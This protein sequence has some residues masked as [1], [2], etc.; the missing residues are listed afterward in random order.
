M[1]YTVLGPTLGRAGQSHSSF[2]DL[3]AAGSHI[4]AQAVPG[5][6]NW[7]TVRPGGEKEDL[8]GA[9]PASATP[10]ST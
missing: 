10:A 5:G 1:P 9:R 6:L 8:P 7:S 4:G 2:S 3:S